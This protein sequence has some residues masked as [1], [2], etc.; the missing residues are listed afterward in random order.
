MSHMLTDQNRA[1]IVEGLE[2]FLQKNATSFSLPGHKSG[3]GAAEDVKRLLGEGVFKSDTSTQ[4]GVD[5]RLESQRVL[6][7]AQHLA[8]LA[9]GADHCYFSTNGTSLSN[10]VASF[11][12]QARAT[13]CWWRA[14]VTNRSLPD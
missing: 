6:Q 9:W 10:H 11:A 1:P 12:R 8:A 2:A 7:N 4:K 13:P 14:T 3:K 5:D